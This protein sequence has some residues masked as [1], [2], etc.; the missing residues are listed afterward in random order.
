MRRLR[1]LDGTIGSSVAGSVGSAV[2]IGIPGSDGGAAAW[3]PAQLYPSWWLDANDSSSITIATGVSQW[4]DKSGNDRNAEQ[5]TAGSQ[6]ILVD[7]G[8]GKNCLSFD[9][10]NDV[11]AISIAQTL[12]RHIFV[13]VDT[14]ALSTSSCAFMDRDTSGGAPYPPALYF[15]GL[16]PR[17]AIMYWGLEFLADQLVT[18]QTKVIYEFGVFE[19]TAFTRANDTAS[20]L[21]NAAHANTVVS[22]WTSINSAVQPSMCN[23]AEILGSPTVLSDDNRH[24]LCGYL[25][26]KWDIES[27][28]PSDH[29]YKDT[30]P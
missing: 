23:I 8:N 24:K 10:G 22:T 12:V 1:S 11:L 14:T 7:W 30:A 9:G 27:V 18:R 13:V 5:A 19:G 2:T 6:P 16:T 21:K 25:A 26:H 17:S 20:T 4:R 29:P 28:L 3:S 15:G